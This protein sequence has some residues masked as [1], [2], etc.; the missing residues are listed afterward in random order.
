MF[1][2]EIWMNTKLLSVGN[3][4]GIN[5]TKTNKHCKNTGIILHSVAVSKISVDTD[6]C[7][8]F[9]CFI[10]VSLIRREL[11]MLHFHFLPLDMEMFGVRTFFG[12]T[13]RGR[14]FT[15]SSLHRLIINPRRTSCMR[16]APVFALSIKFSLNG[17]NTLNT[18]NSRNLKIG[19]MSFKVL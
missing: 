12:S 2:D 8:L 11:N 19:N 6:S 7:T 9:N 13:M 16:I 10:D 17:T 1:N 4:V 18:G 3:I 15:L 5:L 14:P